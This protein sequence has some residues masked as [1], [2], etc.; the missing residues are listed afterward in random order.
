MA[1]TSVNDTNILHWL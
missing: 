1:F